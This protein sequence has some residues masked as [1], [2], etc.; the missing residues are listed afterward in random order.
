M[1]VDRADILIVDD[2]ADNVR[3]LSEILGS[4]GYKSRKVLSGSHA[5]DSAQLDPP[6][7]ILLDI[8]M[9]GMDGYETCQ[10]L[11][12][13]PRTQEIPIIFLSA[14]SDTEDKVKALELGG[15]D[16]I[17]KPF[18]KE[19][20]IARV[21]T[22]LRI[23]NLTQTLR[24][25]NIQLAEEIEHR[26]TVE[27]ALKQA[28]EDLKTTQQ[29]MI[30]HEKLAA[31]GTLTAGIAHEL[32]N[33]LNFVNNY[34]E[35]SIELLDELR[36]LIEPYTS[37]LEPEIQAAIRELMLDLKTN[38]GTIH[39]HGQRAE[40]IISSMMQHARMENSL[41]QLTDLNGLLDEAVDLTYH[42]KR[43][44]NVGFNIT[45]HRNYGSNIGQLKLLPSEL[46]RAFINLIDN[47]F[48]AIQS[49][50]KLV[51]KD[52]VPMLLLTTQQLENSVQ[53]CIQDNGIGIQ[54][55]YQGKIFEP[56]FTTKPT[57][58]GTGLGLSMAYE[59]IV[60]QHNGMLKLDTEPGMHTTF[61]V[62]LPISG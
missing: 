38:S 21:K 30:A 10:Q 43:A 29:Q 35:G 24:A 8:M 14:L 26:K 7:L 28:L 52:F 19:E 61:V 36:D 50:Q 54:P 56:F 9:P 40:Q 11:K 12:A 53:I 34:A 45:I 48:Y 57:G 13:N 27:V 5:L 23:Q 6:D 4:E 55:D 22:H 17:T 15:V 3:L 41:P 32:R 25:Q 1:M 18:Q 39:L 31:L 16:Y 42:S 49:K 20:V 37:K 51:G 60:R 46:C 59:I 58:E 62:T 47:A 33:P 2:K 44:Q